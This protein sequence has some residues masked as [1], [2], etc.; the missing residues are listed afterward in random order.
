MD[1]IL[2]GVR[3]PQSRESMKAG[4]G[5]QDGSLPVAMESFAYVQYTRDFRSRQGVIRVLQPSVP[6]KNQSVQ[7]LAGAVAGTLLCK[8]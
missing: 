2:S 8:K 7:A 6:G 3:S 4:Q 1:E 5:W